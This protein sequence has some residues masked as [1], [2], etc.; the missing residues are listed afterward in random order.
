MQCYLDK[1]YGTD[2]DD[3][4]G[5]PMWFYE[6]DESDREHIL[7]QLKDM[8]TEFNPIVEGIPEEVDIQFINPITE[9]DISIS[10]T[11]EPYLNDL[12]VYKIVDKDN[13][14]Q[15]VDML[16]EFDRTTAIDLSLYLI[17]CLSVKQ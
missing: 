14:Q 10:I 6:P 4:R 7:D 8:L 17:E 15:F 5:T 12:R 9:D 11:T 3:N 1:N 2:R 16:V 13:Y